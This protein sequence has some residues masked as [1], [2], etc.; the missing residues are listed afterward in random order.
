MFNIPKLILPDLVFLHISSLGMLHDLGI[1]LYRGS[2][3][4]CFLS[5][6]HHDTVQLASM[7]WDLSLY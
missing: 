7:Q 5:F 3:T 4:N 2:L 1:I 6:F